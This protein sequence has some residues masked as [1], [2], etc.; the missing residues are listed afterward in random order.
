VLDAFRRSIRLV[1]WRPG[2]IVNSLEAFIL[3]RVEPFVSGGRGDPIS[4]TRLTHRPPATRIVAVELLTLLRR[5]RTI[6]GI[7]QV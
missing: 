1:Q 5:V 6:Q 3:D 2:A 7:L 4:I